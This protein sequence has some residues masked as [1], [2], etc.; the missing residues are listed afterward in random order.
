MPFIQTTFPAPG[1][2][3]EQHIKLLRALV[4]QVE[5]IHVTALAIAAGGTGYAVG[6]TGTLTGTGSGT[7]RT[8]T[9]LT[10]FDMRYV[11]TSVAAGVVDGI[12]IESAGA[13]STA[14]DPTNA[15]IA[16][17][18][19]TGAGTGLTLT[20][21]VLGPYEAIPVAGGSGYAVGDLFAVDDFTGATDPQFRVL[22]VSAGAVLTAAQHTLGTFAFDE[23]PLAT[24]ATTAQTG[25]GDD[26]LTVDINQIGWQTQERDDTDDETDFDWIG[27]GTNLAG[28]DPYVGIRTFT[29]GGSA[30]WNMM[31]ATGY[32][33]AILFHQQ[34]GISPTTGPGARPLGS[35]SSGDGGVDCRLPL[36]IGGTFELFVSVSG[37]RIIAVCRQSPSYEMIYLGLFTPFIDDPANKYPLPFIVAGTTGRSNEDITS[38][39]AANT[40]PHAALP[41]HGGANGCYVIRWLDGTWNKISIG[42]SSS[43][44]NYWL[45]PHRDLPTVI[46]NPGPDPINPAGGVFTLAERQSPDGAPEDAI[47]SNIGG[48]DGF[49]PLPFG[50]GN[51]TH[52]V[53]PYVVVQ[54]VQGTG[55]SQVIGELDGVRHINGESL[56]AEDRVAIPTGETAVVF[57]NTNAATNDL[58]YAVLEV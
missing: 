49:S 34:P 47:L 51:Q 37:R 58:F 33:N 4:D 42:A 48:V 44:E 23:I 57:V 32:N 17:A 18:T 10:A 56:A 39:Y 50:V 55:V 52:P 25:A 53:T 19:L 3:Q 22:T 46:E 21:T 14:P 24:S 6:D 35:G 20:V 31:G 26:A 2:S 7:A 12:A 8:G 43:T 9:G 41:Q 30:Q 5:A 13:Y 28:S 54:D 27:R 29:D 36:A 1:A 40:A 15:A 16:T 45:W 11:V 38:A